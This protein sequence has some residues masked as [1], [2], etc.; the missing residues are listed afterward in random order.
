MHA[1]IKKE[2][3]GGEEEGKKRQGHATKQARVRERNKI[4][5]QEQARRNHT[6]C[7]LTRASA[8]CA[9]CACKSHGRT[10]PTGRREGGREGGRK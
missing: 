2:R 3:W 7:L 9:T 8:G 10:S 5:L 4:T 6:T 1:G